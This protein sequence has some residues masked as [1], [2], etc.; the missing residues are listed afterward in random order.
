MGEIIFPAQIAD[1]LSRN[2]LICVSFQG[3]EEGLAAFEDVAPG[4]FEVAGIPGVGHFAGTGGVV[5]EHADPAVGVAATDAGH[6]ADVPLVHADEQVEAVVVAAGH[7]T[8]PLSLA[9][10]AVLGQFATGGGIDL[11]TDLLGGGGGRFNLEFTLEPCLADEV[12]H[13]ELRHRTA[14]DIAVTDKQYTFHIGVQR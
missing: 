11:V 1:G 14:A 3:F 2:Y 10:D 8:G 13:D 7:L 12:L 5:H 4:G 9:A 6:V